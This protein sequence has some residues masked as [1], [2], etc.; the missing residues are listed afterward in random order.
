MT[1]AA[2]GAYS[3]LLLDSVMRFDVRALAPFSQAKVRL[4]AMLPDELHL[5][6]LIAGVAGICALALS[7]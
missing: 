2:L 5:I 3:H 4:A 7:R 6:C 1:F